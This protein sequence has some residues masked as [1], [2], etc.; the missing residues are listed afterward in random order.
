M[1]EFSR[2]INLAIERNQLI[3]NLKPGVSIKIASDMPIAMR[4]KEVSE[5]GKYLTEAASESC[6]TRMFKS[7]NWLIQ[8]EI[9]GGHTIA[10]HVGKTVAELIERIAT[11]RHITKASTFTDMATAEEVIFETITRNKSD[12]N[13]WLKKASS[14]DRLELIYNG[15]VEIGK[16]IYMGADT[17]TSLKNAVVV[18]KSSGNGKY[19][20]LTSY[21][22]F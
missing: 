10:R 7:N 22:I 12:I 5:I 9:M 2:S 15:V 17:R 1:L 21:P 6:C 20:I 3:Q 18:V 16:G 11:Y 13:K 14:G 8:H 19:F 4:I